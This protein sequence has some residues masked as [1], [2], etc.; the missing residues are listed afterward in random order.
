[1]A[2][3]KVTLRATLGSRSATPAAALASQPTQPATPPSPS[4]Q[5]AATAAPP[6]SPHAT[7]VPAAPRVSFYDNRPGTNFVIKAGKPFEQV[8]EG[9]KHLKDIRQLTF[10]GEN[11]EA[12]FS[13]DG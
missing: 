7:E 11:A 13:P 3:E 10:G 9:E 2:G 5:P 12:Y 8:F 4:A 1:R 6:S